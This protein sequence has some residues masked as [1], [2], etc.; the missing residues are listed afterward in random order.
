M[1]LNR[2]KLLCLAGG[3]T[4]LAVI[5]AGCGSATGS[6]PSGPVSAGN[7]SDLAVGALL[8]M[9]NV[10]VARDENGLYTYTGRSYDPF[11]PPPVRRLLV[12]LQGDG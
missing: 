4:G 5:G 3:T 10:V 12:L 1:T 9:S 8:V 11:V 6:P 2:R 7:V